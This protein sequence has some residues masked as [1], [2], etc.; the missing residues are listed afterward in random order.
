MQHS[1]LRLLGVA[2]GR[3]QV[4]RV[5][6]GRE[7]VAN[8]F[9]YGDRAFEVV[10]GDD[11]HDGA[12]DLFL[13]HAHARVDVCEDRCLD[14]VARLQVLLRRLAAISHYVSALTLPLRTVYSTLA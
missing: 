12:E 9:R 14:E 7:T 3:T 4:A 1:G 5:D 8:G 10:R 2:E 6:R 11:A 13:R